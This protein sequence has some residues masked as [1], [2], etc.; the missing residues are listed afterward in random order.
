MCELKEHKK[1]MSRNSAVNLV[2]Y[3]DNFDA[4]PSLIFFQFSSWVEQSNSNSNFAIESSSDLNL[5]SI[6]ETRERTNYFEK[7]SSYRSNVD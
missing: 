5:Q 3:D 4:V 2:D 1:P 7:V 6:Q